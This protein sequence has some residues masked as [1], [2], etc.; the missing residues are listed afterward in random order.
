M[1]RVNIG[2][3]VGML[4]LNMVLCEILLKQTRHFVFYFFVYIELNYLHLN[5][6]MIVA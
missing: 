3:V 5:V 1:G 2:K 4:R 6:V